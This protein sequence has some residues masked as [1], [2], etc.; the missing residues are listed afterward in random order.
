MDD[1]NERTTIGTGD[2]RSEDATCGLK[3]KPE[4]REAFSD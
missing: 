3:R 4:E 2:A 1:G